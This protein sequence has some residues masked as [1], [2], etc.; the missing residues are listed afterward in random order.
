MCKKAD[1]S[2]KQFP[3][4]GLWPEKLVLPHYPEELL[5]VPEMKALLQ[6]DIT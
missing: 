3:L 2:L 4:T 1:T 6:S 5:K